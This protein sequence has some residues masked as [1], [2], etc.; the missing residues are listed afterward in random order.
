[1]LRLSIPNESYT[2][3]HWSWKEGTKTLLRF[4][5]DTGITETIA[6]NHKQL[7]FDVYNDR[8]P[9]RD[10]LA[11]LADKWTL[12]VLARLESEPMRFNQL[13]RDVRKIT[14]KVLTQTLRKLER[15]GLIS[16]KVFPTVPVTVE[17]SLTPLGKTL[18]ETVSVMAHWAEHNMEA[19]LT[20]QMAYDSAN[21]AITDG[22]SDS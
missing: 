14:Q 11:R 16:R 22:K 2:H 5:K 7:S 9:A 1:M 17:Y 6:M 20:A 13:K 21:A 12:L 8:C 15:D 10:V 18:T 3:Y 4:L 19:I